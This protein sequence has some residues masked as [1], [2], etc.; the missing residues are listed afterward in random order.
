MKARSWFVVIALFLVV[1]GVAIAQTATETPDPQTVIGAPQGRPLSGDELARV[2]HETS[3]LL[4]CPVC[5]GLSI[6]DSPSSMATRM[7]N[8]VREM[9]AAGYTPEQIMNYFEKSYGQLVR[10]EPPLRGVNWLV[11]IA[12]I[13]ALLIGAV[14]IFSSTKSLRRGSAAAPAVST[15]ESE[16]AAAADPE[17]AGYLDRVR[18]E[19]Y[20]ASSDPKKG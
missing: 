19:A 15:S 14:I 16:S 20:G 4:R 1:A 8:E 2:T 5:Q 3:V 9:L 18:R 11:W 10:L 13:A 7:R 17:L 6:A 12:P